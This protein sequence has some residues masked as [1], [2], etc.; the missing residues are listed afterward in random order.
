MYLIVFL[1]KLFSIIQKPQWL[2]TPRGCIKYLYQ[3][4]HVYMEVFHCMAN[5]YL[6]CQSVLGVYSDAYFVP[7]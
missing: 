6:K 7:F 2:S 4:N 3:P 1:D 5:L